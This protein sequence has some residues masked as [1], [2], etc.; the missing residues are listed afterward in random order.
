[1]KLIA[2]ILCVLS[3]VVCALYALIPSPKFPQPPA[4]ALQ[5]KEPAD[6]ESIYRRSYYTNYTRAE[7][8]SYYSSQFMLPLQLRLN[9]P[10]EEA[11]TLIRDQARSSYLEELVH[12]FRE[13][14]YINGFEPTKPTEQIYFGSTHYNNKITIRMIPSQAVTRLTV[15]FLTFITCWYFAKEYV[16][17]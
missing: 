2:K 15:L 3:L 13:T 11:A 12:P 10:P 16:Q 4:N 8:M 6:T 17:T 5:S 7:I 14:L 9:H 1:M